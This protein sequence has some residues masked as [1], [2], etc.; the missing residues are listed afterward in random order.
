MFFA[1]SDRELDSLAA[2]SPTDSELIASS[3]GLLLSDLHYNSTTT[4]AE[5]SAWCVGLRVRY[6]P[7]GPEDQDPGKCL[8]LAPD[9]QAS[10]S[11]TLLDTTLFV[12]VDRGKIMLRGPFAT[13]L[14]IS[15]NEIL[16]ARPKGL[17]EAVLSRAPH[18]LEDLLAIMGDFGKTHN[19]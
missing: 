6:R 14:E 7:Q 17:A 1:L 18:T 13:F 3:S 5:G 9:V 16:E 12:E 8:W 10:F 19:V 2:Q 11:L 4:S 15:E